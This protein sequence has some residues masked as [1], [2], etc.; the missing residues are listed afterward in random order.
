MSKITPAQKEIIL[1]KPAS[2]AIEIII[3]KPLQLKGKVVCNNKTQIECDF[4]SNLKSKLL[5]KL[6]VSGSTLP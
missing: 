4:G 2:V 6:F 1:N 5:G 3:S